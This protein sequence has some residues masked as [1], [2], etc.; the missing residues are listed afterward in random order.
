MKLILRPQLDNVDSLNRMMKFSWHWYNSQSKT[1]QWSS[2]W[3]LKSHSL[4]RCFQNW[5]NLSTLSIFL[6]QV[7]PIRLQSRP[8]KSITSNHLASSDRSM[9]AN[10]KAYIGHFRSWISSSLSSWKILSSKRTRMIFSSKSLMSAKSNLSAHPVFMIT[11][12]S[13][14]FSLSRESSTKS[15]TNNSRNSKKLLIIL[16]VETKVKWWVRRNISCSFADS[17]MLLHVPHQFTSTWMSQNR[18]P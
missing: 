3:P 12:H 2:I 11:R 16:E 6:A 9:T 1:W 15:S 4:S 17:G 13:F 14:L 8:G 7:S 5:T 10:R 18:K